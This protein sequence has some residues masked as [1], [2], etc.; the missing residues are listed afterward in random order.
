MSESIIQDHICR[1]GANRIAKP[2]LLNCLVTAV[3]LA[4]STIAIMYWL[5]ENV[6]TTY[7]YIY[8]IIVVLMTL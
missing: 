3:M 8:D 7:I 5:V 4:I 2:K 1:R 6:I